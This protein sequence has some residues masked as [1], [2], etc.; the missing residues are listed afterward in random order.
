MNFIKTVHLAALCIP[1]LITACTFG[2]TNGSTDGT[3]SS[4]TTTTSSSQMS[5]SQESAYES[6][7]VRIELPRPNAQVASPLQVEGEA[8][9]TWFFEASLPL[10]L[11]TAAGETLVE[12]AVMTEDEWMTEDFVGFSTS[13]DFTVTEPTAAWLVVKRSNPSGLPEND[14]EEQI[15]ITLMPNGSS[16]VSQ[17]TEWSTFTSQQLGIAIDHPSEMMIERVDSNPTASGGVQLSLWGPT[18]EPNTEFFDGISVTLFNGT[19]TKSIS[20]LVDE[21][22]QDVRAVGSVE[23]APHNTTVAGMNATAYTVETL[24]LYTH[25]FVRTEGNDYL[26]IITSS[27]DPEG[28]GYAAEV[29]AM[30]ATLR[31]L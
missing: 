10:E 2:D 11:R 4:Q 28:M 7:N 20:T 3:S 16:S 13:I 6:N 19:S 18:Q 17:T 27:P 1:V 21:A 26:H 24:G 29:D 30:L 12:T 22:L 9:G 23:V 5:S 31:R 15:A 8:S 25:Y 14:E